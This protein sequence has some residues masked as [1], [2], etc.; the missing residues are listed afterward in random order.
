MS[1]SDMATDYPCAICLGKCNGHTGT[2]DPKKTA[3]VSDHT[4]QKF[5]GDKDEPSL[6]MNGCAL[7][8]AGV[9]KV[10]SFGFKKY[11]QRGGWK[12]VPEA[13]RRYKD[14]LY[15]HLQKIEEGELID[16]ES[17]LPHIDHVACN[18][19]FLSQM[20]KESK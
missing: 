16:P 15:R 5:D 8:V 18:A 10:L 2:A 3:A 13:P 11:K 9:V 14:A 19:M 1:L 20:S 6:L 12:T 7:A 17:G 4:G